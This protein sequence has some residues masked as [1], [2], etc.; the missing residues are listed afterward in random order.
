M[1]MLIISSFSSSFFR[2]KTAG[3]NLSQK[4][5]PTFMLYSLAKF[6]ILSISFKFRAKGFSIKTHLH[7]LKTF[8]AIVKC[9]FVGVAMMIISLF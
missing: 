3:L 9:E 5:T 7:C 6:E 2:A 8:F 1:L 4:P